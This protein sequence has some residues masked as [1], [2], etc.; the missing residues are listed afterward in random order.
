MAKKGCVS[1]WWGVCSPKNDF[2]VGWDNGVRG[3]RLHI[4]DWRLQ[5]GVGVREKV[6]EIAR[7]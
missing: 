5:I 6:R 7:K 3:S 1:Y 2:F 4:T